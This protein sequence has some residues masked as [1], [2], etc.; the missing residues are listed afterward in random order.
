M[1]EK[2]INLNYTYYDR[3]DLLAFVVDYYNNHNG[4]DT[5]TFNIIDDGSPNHPITKD[6]VPEDWNVLRVTEDHGWGNEVSRNIMMR[7]NTAR[8]C[9]LIDLDY[10]I[11]LEYNRSFYEKAFWKY[12]AKNENAPI[13]YQFE[14]GKRTAYTDV[15]KKW[16]ED[17]Q[18][19][20]YQKETENYTDPPIN[21]FVI[22]DWAWK[23]QTYGYDMAYGYL[24]GSDTTLAWQCYD[25]D[26]PGTKLIKHATQVDE[27]KNPGDQSVYEPWQRRHRQL[28]K[29]CSKY[30]VNMQRKER[31]EREP[32]WRW[33]NDSESSNAHLKH[34]IEWPEVEIVQNNGL[35][36]L[37]VSFII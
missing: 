33:L 31:F 26:M 37:P 8:W 3:P 18:S 22:S 30:Y 19:A 10:V 11:D 6:M 7:V 34:C 32:H 2:K 15:N 16:G 23:N 21:S 1:K 5:F 14:K 36:F 25:H 20:E 9:C 28:L 4:S 12:Y 27:R 17:K 35:P 24:Y 29:N 13:M